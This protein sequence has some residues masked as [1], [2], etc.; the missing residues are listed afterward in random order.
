MNDSWREFKSISS[1]IFQ[2]GENTLCDQVDFYKTG[3]IKKIKI[4]KHRFFKI[5]L[6]GVVRGQFKI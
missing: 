1:E 5:L 2:S 4:N 3:S 6:P